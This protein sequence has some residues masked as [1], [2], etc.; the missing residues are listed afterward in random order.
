MQE[1]ERYS[2]RR[3]GVKVGALEPWVDCAFPVNAPGD[4]DDIALLL[5]V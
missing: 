1:Q 5:N 4:Y 2:K 3:L